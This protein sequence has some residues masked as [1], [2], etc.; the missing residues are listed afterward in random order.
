LT[1]YNKSGKIISGNNT[2]FHL[3]T[4]AITTLEK[5]QNKRVRQKIG[6]IEKFSE[7]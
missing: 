4:M 5:I 6:W 2:G 7:Q 3:N 1:N